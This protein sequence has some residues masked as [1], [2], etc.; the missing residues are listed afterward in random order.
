M[1]T[2]GDTRRGEGNTVRTD[3]GSG[4]SGARSPHLMSSVIGAGSSIETETIYGW[5][6]ATKAWL[7]IEKE[8]RNYNPAHRV[9][10]W[11]NDRYLTA[12]TSWVPDNKVIYSYALGLLQ[13]TLVSIYQTS[14]NT[15]RDTS[16]QA[17]SYTPAG[18][19]EYVYRMA[20]ASN[21]RDTA[22][23]YQFYYNAA[24]D[25]I[26]ME[27][28]DFSR[29]GPVTFRDSD[30]Y[31][32]QHQLTEV[33]EWQKPFTGAAGIRPYSKVTVS[34]LDSQASVIECKALDTLFSNVADQYVD[35]YYY[36]TYQPAVVAPGPDAGIRFRIYPQPANNAAY[37]SCRLDQPSIL[38]I[39]VLDVT[40]RT[41][42]HI[43]FPKSDAFDLVLPLGALSSGQYLVRAQT[44]TGSFTQRLIVAH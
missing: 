28:K 18:D 26:A 29:L 30:V 8:T 40:G 15:W 39:T 1:R 2:R 3:D 42:H 13:N 27:R 35:R 17:F 22:H 7:P 25:E 16:A 6:T 31:N 43:D 5:D 41:V 33:Y 24:R 21:R 37:I 11:I 10:Q 23:I 12:T 38:N 4:T 19:I 14:S 36:E 32:S 34:Y 20:I 44:G 9:T